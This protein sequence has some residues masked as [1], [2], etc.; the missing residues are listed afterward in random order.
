MNSWFC[1][2]QVGLAYPGRAWRV[3]R[4]SRRTGGAMAGSTAARLVE[5]PN[6]PWRRISGLTVAVEATL[7]AKERK[8]GLRRLVR[9]AEKFVR[10]RLVGREA[11][12]PLQEQA[13]RRERTGCERPQPVAPPSQRSLTS[14]FSTRVR[15]G[16]A[17]EL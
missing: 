15:C 3:H 1:Q 11:G 13:R 10:A 5:V 2:Q 17:L 12:A 7:T 6:E 16:R 4:G 9:F 14:R 8:R